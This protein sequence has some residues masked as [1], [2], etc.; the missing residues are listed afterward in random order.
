MKKQTLSRTRIS[1]Q[2]FSEWQAARPA[3]GTLIETYLRSRGLHISAQSVLRFHSGLKHPSGGV[4]PAMVALVTRGVDGAQI[5]IH[6]TFLARDGSG[7]GP[8]DPA[9]MML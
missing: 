7:K 2:V 3:D 9:K 4:W 5:A 6:R 8:I 1:R